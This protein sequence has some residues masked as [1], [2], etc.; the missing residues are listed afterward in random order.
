MKVLDGTMNGRA[1]EARDTGDEGDTPSPQLFGIDGGNKVLLSLIQM[2]EQ[3]CILLLKLILFAHAGSITRT[4]SIVT[5]NFL[6]VHTTALY[7]QPSAEEL[8]DDLERS[9]MNVYG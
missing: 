8:A 4:L 3:R 6:R 2:G 9:R 7:T 1:R 5:L